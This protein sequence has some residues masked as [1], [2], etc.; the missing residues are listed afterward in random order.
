MI[1]EAEQ[2]ARAMSADLS[3]VVRGEVA[4]KA[5]LDRMARRL[6]SILKGKA[7]LRYPPK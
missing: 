6:E 5:G 7:K 3:R 2:I 4:P 1:P